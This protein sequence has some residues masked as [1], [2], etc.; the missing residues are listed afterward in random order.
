MSTQTSDTFKN[1]KNASLENDLGT[2][3][4]KFSQG[5]ASLCMFLQGF[6][7]FIF[8]FRVFCFCFFLFYFK[9]FF[10][11]I[12]FRHFARTEPLL[13]GTLQEKQPRLFRY[14]ATFLAFRKNI[15]TAFAI[16]KF[17]RT[18]TL[19]KIWGFV[20]FFLLVFFLFFYENFGF[21]FFFFISLLIL[22][23]FFVF[24][25]TYFFNFFFSVFIPNF[26]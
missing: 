4:R 16:S 8:S 7:S 1:T 20:Y 6:V 25:F 24:F 2:S 14:F 17:T 13:P 3:F 10:Y 19:T 9:I 18:R 15:N 5:F 11:F 21:F 22:F 26:F 23:V 12:I